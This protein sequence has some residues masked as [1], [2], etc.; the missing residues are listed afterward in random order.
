MIERDEE[1]GL[2]RLSPGGSRVV[3]AKVRAAGKRELEALPDEAFVEVMAN[4]SH[5]YAHA[6]RMTA[7]LL[8]REFMFG[9]QPR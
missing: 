9:T 3:A 1:R 5:R 7:H 2:W 6:D 4:V 8:R